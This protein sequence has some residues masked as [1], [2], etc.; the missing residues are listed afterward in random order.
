V[1]AVEA[2]DADQH[3]SP[4]SI[5]EV[6]GFLPA[7]LTYESEQCTLQGSLPD[8]VAMKFSPPSWEGELD[9]S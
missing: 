2:G 7:Q 9:L 1:S 6:I 5:E 4:N 8:L 3:A